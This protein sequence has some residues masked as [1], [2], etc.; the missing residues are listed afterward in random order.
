MAKM[1]G[2]RD[3][4]PTNPLPGVLSCYPFGLHNPP[5]TRVL[6]NLVLVIRYSWSLADW[7]IAGQLNTPCF[8]SPSAH[9]SG[10][11]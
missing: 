2:R 1:M 9:K 8:Q 11:E 3:R 10:I 4:Y 7:W 6:C 5:W